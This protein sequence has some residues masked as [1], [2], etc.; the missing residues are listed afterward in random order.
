MRKPQQKPKSKL[1]DAEQSKRFI[2]TAKEVGADDEKALD[3]AFK[4]IGFAQK[5]KSAKK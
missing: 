2:E 5:P 1:Q 4:K 3:N